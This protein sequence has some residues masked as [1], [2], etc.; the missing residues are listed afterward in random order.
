MAPIR[1]LLVDDHV[2]FRKG[3]ASLLTLRGLE[4]V[5]EACN[6][7]EAFEMARE[8]KPDLVLM[9]INMPMLDGIAATRLLRSEMPSLKIVILTVSDE[10]GDLFQA[11]KAGASG[12]L[13]KNMEPNELFDMLEG[14]FRGEAA[15]TR[16]L[17]AKILAE[18]SQQAQRQP[19]AS[20]PRSA[21]TARETQ[22]LQYVAQGA[23]NR[24]IAGS[25]CISENTVKNHLRNILE[26]LHLPNRV[27]AVAYALREGLI[28][29]PADPGKATDSIS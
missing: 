28:H 22:V 21:L 11:I 1:T 18:F 9:D 29:N 5:G 27:Q 19:V 12:Y 8:L 26:K 23:C 10:D 15:I 16:A 13:L 25:L 24:E 14:T 2:L 7:Q 6:G 4:I 20:A 17:A 3:L